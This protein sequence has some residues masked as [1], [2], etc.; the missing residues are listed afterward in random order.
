MNG[1]TNEDGTFKV[2]DVKNQRFIKRGKEFHPNSYFYEKNGNRLVTDDGF[3]DSMEQRYGKIENDVS[4]I[5]NTINQSNSEEKY[6]INDDDIVKL[7]FF[8]SVMYWRI[9]S[10][11]REIENIIKQKPLK[12]LGLVLKSTKENNV[13][14]PL[15]VENEIKKNPNLMKMMKYWFP[16]IS[17]PEIFKCE[18]KLHIREFPKG[19]PSICGDNP[20]ICQNPNTFRVYT[21]DYIFPINNTKIF[22]RGDN[23]QSELSTVKIELDTLIYKQSFKYV[24]CTDER[25]IEELENFYSKHFDNLNQLR[26]LI[27]YRFFRSSSIGFL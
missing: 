24:S 2:Y 15:E 11:Y 20:I 17:F 12:D 1:F 21:S 7:Q 26:D 13:F 6:N 10:N 25:Y 5:F 3:D 9:P 14:S 23:I 16:H 4:L 27:F 8:V 19:L 22:L 18:S